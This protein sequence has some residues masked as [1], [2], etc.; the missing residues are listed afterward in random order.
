MRTFH[1]LVGMF[2]LGGVA[3]L[4]AG[5]CS[6]TTSDDDDG[7]GGTGTGGTTTTTTSTSSQ[8][9]GGS[10]GGDESTSCEDA[11]VLEAGTNSL[12]GTFYRYD[13]AVINPAQDED[14]FKFTATAG[15][16]IGIL[17]DANPDDI[18]EMIDT[19]V[20]LYN[21]DGTTMLAEVD[22]SFPRATTD[23]EMFH[24]ITAAGTYCVKVQEFSDWNGDSPEGDPTFLYDIVVLPI[25]FALYDEYNLDTEPNNASGTAQDSLSFADLTNSQY[26]T[27]LAGLL[28]PG[29]DVDFYRVTAPAGAIALSVDLTAS[30]VDNGYGST[31]GPGM[32]SIYD[33]TGATL[34]AQVDNAQQP[35][36]LEG[37]SAVPA[38]P[39]DYLLEVTRLATTG[40]P[41]KA[42]SV[43]ASVP[44][45]PV[46]VRLG[47]LREPFWI[48]SFSKRIGPSCLGELRLKTSPARS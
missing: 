14:F 12:G 35:N 41:R 9:G 3:A 38:V 20:T 19:V 13:D 18:P 44:Y 34:L 24:R 48:S 39:G 26:F 29:D 15:Q 23:T 4:S 46:F 22:D 21:E 36:G 37:M 7:G 45:A 42:S 33:T 17:T 6:S 1:V 31:K 47:R 32:V 27:Q 16:W 40:W 8:G 25:D 43:A 11:I 28:D 10:S 30:Q 2:A 5:G